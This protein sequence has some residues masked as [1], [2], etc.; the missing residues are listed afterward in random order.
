MPPKRTSTFDAP[1]MNQAAIKQLVIDSVDAAL[2]A[3]DANMANADNTNR[4]PKPS[5][6]LVARKCSYKEF[7]S[8]QPF[9][10]KEE[11]STTTTTVTPPPTTATII[12][13]YNRTGDKKPSGL[14]LPPQL[15]TVGHMTRNCRNKGPA[16]G[17]NLLRPATGSNLLPVTVTFHACREKGHYIIQC[18]KTTNN[19]A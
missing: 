16:T 15:R 11:L 8:S 5:E 1:A 12:T 10:F 17:S 14:M 3:Q 18:R 6:A 7:M 2:K 19:N 9:N 13:S 4:N